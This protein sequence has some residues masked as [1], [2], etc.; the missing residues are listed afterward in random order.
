MYIVTFHGP[1][2]G[3][4]QIVVTICKKN[5]SIYNIGLWVGQE[6]TTVSTVR[7]FKPRTMRNA[8][9]PFITESEAIVLL[10]LLNISLLRCY[11]N[12]TSTEQCADVPRIESL[13]TFYP[14]GKNLLGK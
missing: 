8:L 9:L 6:T 11:N 1:V 13:C 3:D 7:I 12:R 10:H 5:C 2:A 14:H 4:G